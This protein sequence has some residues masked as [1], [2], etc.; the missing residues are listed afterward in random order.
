MVGC[1]QLLAQVVIFKDDACDTCP[2][3]VR[4]LSARF[5]LDTVSIFASSAVKIIRVTS[6]DNFLDDMY[7]TIY[8]IVNIY[9]SA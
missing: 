3:L 5:Q 8:T 2:S 9:S 4:S 7:E 1:R 6:Q